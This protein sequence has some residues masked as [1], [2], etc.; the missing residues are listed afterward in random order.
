MTQDAEASKSSP[1]TRSLEC[2]EA[3]VGWLDSEEVP[4]LAHGDLEAQLDMKGRELLRQ[5]FQDHLDLR[6]ERERRLE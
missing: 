5:L 3:I 2:F 6:S 1:Y 4:W